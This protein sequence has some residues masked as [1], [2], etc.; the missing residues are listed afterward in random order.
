MSRI[1][2]ETTEIPDGG[3]AAVWPSSSVVD[4][5]SAVVLREFLL[6]G[7][8]HRQLMHRVFA[9]Q[10]LHPAQAICVAVLA[11]HGELAQSEIADALILSRP[12]VTRLLQRMERGG[13]VFRRP[14]DT[15]QRQTLVSLTSAGR[16]LQHRMDEAEAEYAMSTLAQL[17]DDDR[18]Q[19]ARILPVW[20]RLAEATR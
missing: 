5:V 16:D 14:S 18:A 17:S 12:S 6:L 10:C 8:L 19:L 13:L 15:D 7:R 4:P 2:I 9:K 11:H 20:R 3:R 1:V